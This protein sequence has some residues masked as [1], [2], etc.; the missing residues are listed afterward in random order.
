M[1]NYRLKSVGKLVYDPYRGDMK[2]RTE[3]WCVVQVD[4]EITRYYRYWVR[5]RYGIEL[6]QPSWDAH[7]SVVRGEKPRTEKLR[8]LWGKYQG[9]RVEFEYG[10]EPYNGNAKGTK[11]DNAEVFWMIDVFCPR[12]NEI[13][14]EFGL[15]TF[16]NYHLTIGRTYY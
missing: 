6:F 16:Y 11:H 3:W 4:R 12:F 15:R 1:E 13:R 10:I 2:N 7:T 14:D 9:E 8:A 5:C